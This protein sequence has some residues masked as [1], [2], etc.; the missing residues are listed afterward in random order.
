MNLQLRRVI[1][2]VQD[3]QVVGAFYRDV[4]GLPVIPSPD[5]EHDW[6][7]F[8]AGA[9]RIALH[10]SEVVKVTRRQPKPV[11]YAENVVSTRAVLIARG[12]RLGAV[13]TS[14]DIQFCDGKDPEGN[15]YQI[16]NRP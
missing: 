7:E 4:L 11:F 10:K 12:A 13:Q 5:D 15:P 14:N 6:L 3:V 8:D 16:S 1:V 2:F 9:C